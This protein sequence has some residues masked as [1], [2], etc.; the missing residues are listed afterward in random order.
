LGWCRSGCF[1]GEFWG[2]EAEFGGSWAGKGREQGQGKNAEGA[3]ISVEDAAGAWWAQL[4]WVG[5]VR[6]FWG[7]VAVRAVYVPPITMEL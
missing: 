3:K 5:G 2:E 4:S 7:G 6:G 1:A